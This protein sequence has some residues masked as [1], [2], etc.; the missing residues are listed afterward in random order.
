M[1][2]IQAVFAS[3]VTFTCFGSHTNYFDL[4]P[5]ANRLALIVTVGGVVFHIV[6]RVLRFTGVFLRATFFPLFVIK[7]FSMD[8]VPLFNGFHMVLFTFVTKINGSA[9]VLRERVLTRVFRRERRNNA[10]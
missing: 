6:I 3:V 10:V 1:K 5:S 4:F 9:N 7:Q 2:A 8:V